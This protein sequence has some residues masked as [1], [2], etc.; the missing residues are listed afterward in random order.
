M[1]SR[2][3]EILQYF[4]LKPIP[5][6][7]LQL[8][9]EIVFTLILLFVTIE[10]ILYMRRRHRET[11]REWASFYKL[12]ETED[13][14]VEQMK[15]LRDMAI[16][17]KLRNPSQLLEMIVVFDRCVDDKFRNDKLTESERDRL[18]MELG[19]LRKKLMFDNLP[20]SEFLG[21]THGIDVGQS[22]RIE[23][24]VNERMQ[25]YFTK[26]YKT[27]EMDL[28]VIMPVVPGQDTMFEVGQTIGVYFW[29]AR[30]AGYKFSTEIIDFTKG[31][32]LLLHLAHSD[33]LVR[34]QRRHFFRIDIL[35][36][37]SYHLMSPGESVA[38]EQNG[39][40]SFD[41][42]FEP[43]KGRVI[44]LS[45]GGITFSADISPEKGELIWIELSLP[46]VSLISPILGR[47]VRLKKINHTQNKI[48]TEYAHISEKHRESIIKFIAIQQRKRLNF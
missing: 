25:F 13:L 2:E 31:P 3:R 16:A 18:E 38:W 8:L 48:T 14:S 22:I 19:E 40:F 34:D 27:A 26:V 5:D 39:I 42:D 47:V 37:I 4:R 10:L 1:E 11:K 32:P 12:C 45:G 23:L 30:D 17:S 15:L 9:L 35:L 6:E 24:T 41:E 20:I 7:T 44:G 29:R 36:P 46:K 43:K 21:T 28:Q 33:K